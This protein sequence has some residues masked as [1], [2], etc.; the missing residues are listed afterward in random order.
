[1]SESYFVFCD[2]KLITDKKS[3]ELHGNNDCASTELHK[4]TVHSV[5]TALAIVFG[6][7]IPKQLIVTDY[8]SFIV[9]DNPQQNTV[10]TKLYST[11]ST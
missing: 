3:E 4:D 7:D 9:I 2:C 11:P 1:M 6:T 8:R 10:P 5:I